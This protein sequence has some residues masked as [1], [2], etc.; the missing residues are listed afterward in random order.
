MISLAGG[1]CGVGVQ[2]VD[3]LGTSIVFSWFSWFSFP[4]RKIKY[5]QYAALGTVDQVVRGIENS[6][7]NS[8][9]MLW[10]MYDIV[11]AQGFMFAHWIRQGELQSKDLD[12]N[13][14]YM[15]YAD[16]LRHIVLGYCRLLHCK[17][18]QSQNMQR[19]NVKS[20]CS[21]TPSFPCMR[22]PVCLYPARI[23]TGLYKP[24]EN[25]N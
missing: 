3:I 16:I 14:L 21:G 24:E 22:S 19:Y 18:N 4:T 8:W 9:K 15:I 13:I 1:G 20:G 11:E 23:E 12:W 6:V 5:C 17:F 25:L 2:E 10:I 7:S